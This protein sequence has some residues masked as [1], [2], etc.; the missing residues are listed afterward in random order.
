MATFWV[1]LAPRDAC[2]FPV[3]SIPG[4]APREACSFPVCSIPVVRGM[5]QLSFVLTVCLMRCT[6]FAIWSN[7]VALCILCTSLAA[8]TDW[9]IPLAFRGEVRPI[10]VPATGMIG[11]P[12]TFQ[13][14]DAH[15]FAPAGDLQAMDSR[16]DGSSIFPGGLNATEP[17][18]SD[19]STINPNGMLVVRAVVEPQLLT[20]GIDVPC[21][22]AGL[23]LPSIA[24]LPRNMGRTTKV[25]RRGVL[26]WH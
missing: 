4:A 22:S 2:S 17:F 3:C 26:R 25:V 11:A 15:C 5:F 20:H 19:G 9:S 12:S 21:Q 24:S 14:L 23:L 10:Q 18:C 1:I 8:M 16:C 7:P 6:L 13:G